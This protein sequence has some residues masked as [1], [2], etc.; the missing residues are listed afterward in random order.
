[1]L[2]A[3]VRNLL[4]LKNIILLSLTLISC[5]AFSGLAPT[6]YAKYSEFSEDL[7]ITTLIADESALQGPVT[8]RDI[9]K[10]EIKFL[11]NLS[12]R[13]FRKMIMQSAA[14]N[15]D[16]FTI[17]KNAAHLT[18]FASQFRGEFIRGDHLVISTDNAGGLVSSI[19]GIEIGNVGSDEL[20]GALVNVW[21]GP[22]P[23]SRDFKNALL[24]SADYSAVKIAFDSLDYDVKRRDE[25]AKLSS[26]EQINAEDS[27][28]DEESESE[29]VT[30]PSVAESATA[31]AT[32]SQIQ[33]PTNPAAA[34][35]QAPKSEA[36]ANA[37]NNEAS[38]AKAA[39][40]PAVVN[41]VKVES[42]PVIETPKIAK[43]VAKPTI[44]KAVKVEAN[45]R[46]NEITEEYATELAYHAKRNIVYPKRSMKLGHTGNV[47]ALVTIDRDGQLLE[48]NM[49]NPA[50]FS[51]LNNAVKK[52]IKRSEPYPDIPVPIEGETFTF[53]VPVAFS[54]QG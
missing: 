23:P 5:N 27:I 13:R 47:T 9:K 11:T 8:S 32:T 39:L 52:G 36:T 46:L 44:E 16:P 41:P 18:S 17:R 31:S 54:L 21:I 2:G 6:G 35:E 40:T 51:S 38:I 53:M 30:A 1:M 37:T 33:S 20:F 14:I 10:I 28:T 25:L 45:N 19:N 42:K 43:Q 7:F 49:V 24:G 12:Q 3:K 50:D 4:S 29:T 48:V 26:P 15:N 34:T 22:V